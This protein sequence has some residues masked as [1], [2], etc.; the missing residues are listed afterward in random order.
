M[1][2]KD[3]KTLSIFSSTRQRQRFM[4]EFLD[5]M[6]INVSEFYRNAKRWDVLQTKNISKIIETNKRL[7]IWSA[8]C[9]TGEEPYT[10]SDG[11]IQSSI[12]FLKFPFM[13]QI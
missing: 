4:N 10:T 5:R 8:A 9:S 1:K 7:K 6:T 13:Q 12:L 2:K 3:I 11:V